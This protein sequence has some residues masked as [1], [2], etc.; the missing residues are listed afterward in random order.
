VSEIVVDIP[1]KTPPTHPARDV[2]AGHESL[3][4][5][6]EMTAP[7]VV[8]T[9]KQI[10]MVNYR[11]QLHN[12]ASALPMPTLMSPNTLMVP[13]AL[14]VLPKPPPE[15]RDA[16]TLTDPSDVLREVTLVSAAQFNED[17]SQMTPERIGTD[18]TTT[19]TTQHDNTVCSIG[20]GL[21][22]QTSSML[23]S[24]PTMP[25]CPVV[26]AGLSH[27]VDLVM[28]VSQWMPTTLV[29]P[30][31]TGPQAQPHRPPNLKDPLFPW[32]KWSTHRL[33][34]HDRGSIS[35]LLTA[36]LLY[37][38]AVP[39]LPPPSPF[40]TQTRLDTLR[41]RKER[42]QVGPDKDEAPWNFPTLLSIWV[43]QYG[44]GSISAGWFGGAAMSED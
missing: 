9:K 39:P 40:M 14:P 15:Q 35:P 25:A 37:Q 38:E 7:S 43:S 17:L 31:R 27:G 18:N 36:T 11:A 34:H 41:P 30:P 3:H 10:A 16:C 20:A 13:T 6:L 33:Y 29:Q 42:L 24:N 23:S 28:P 26:V 21:I 12:A 19:M 8:L 32:T 44:Q 2:A 1:P 5:L 22:L 4:C